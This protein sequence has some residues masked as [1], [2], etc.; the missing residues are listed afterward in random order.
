MYYAPTVGKNSYMAVLP[1]NIAV[2][3]ILE[4]AFERLLRSRA[5]V[6]LPKTTPQL[7]IRNV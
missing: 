4:H 1:K 7:F 2:S 6:I 5:A 3:S